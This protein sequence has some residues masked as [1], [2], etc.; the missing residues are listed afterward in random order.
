M[1]QF[2]SIPQPLPPRR[3]SLRV[4]DSPDA[5][6]VCLSDVITLLTFQLTCRLRFTYSWTMSFN[7]FVLYNIKIGIWRIW[8]RICF[9]AFMKWYLKSSDDKVLVFLTNCFHLFMMIFIFNCFGLTVQHLL[10]KWNTL[11]EVE[12]LLKNNAY[13]IFTKRHCII[14]MSLNKKSEV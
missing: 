11:S 7:I 5:D 8:I 13:I 14:F 10:K 2:G 1:W 6:T 4:D 12:Y 9:E 3:I